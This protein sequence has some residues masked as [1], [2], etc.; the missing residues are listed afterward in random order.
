MTDP[1]TAVSHLEASDRHSNYS[2]LVIGVLALAGGLALLYHE[3]T[4]ATRWMVWRLIPASWTLVVVGGLAVFCSV[5]SLMGTRGGGAARVGDDGVYSDGSFIPW[6][7]IDAV[8]VSH[9]RYG[10]SDSRSLTVSSRDGQH[11]TFAYNLEGAANSQD[12]RAFADLHESILRRVNNRLW[13]E[14]LVR[15][16]EGGFEFLP[17]VLLMPDGI[18]LTGKRGPELIPWVLLRRRE[19][20][21]GQFQLIVTDENDAPK[22]KVLGAVSDARNVHLVTQYMDQRLAEEGLYS[23]ERSA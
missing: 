7:D 1:R 10:S 13:K 9:F 18:Y 16:E 15:I 17:D 19:F 20:E 4:A 21:N 5:V 12:S 3:Q 2:Y 11:V 14:M 8:R 22:R 6:N 23:E